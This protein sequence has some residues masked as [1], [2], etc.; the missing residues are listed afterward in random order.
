MLQA[1]WR[2]Q[3]WIP[4]ICPTG[5]IILSLLSTSKIFPLLWWRKKMI[6]T[7]KESEVFLKK[8]I[9]DKNPSKC[10]CDKMTALQVSVESGCNNSEKLF[11]TPAN[12]A[13]EW[14]RGLAG[15]IVKRLASITVK[16]GVAADYVYPA[17]S[18]PKQI[19]D[20]MMAHWWVTVQVI[21]GVAHQHP[22]LEGV[23]CHCWVF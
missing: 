21:D 12:T 14:W 6:E 15:E 3:K 7:R 20:T 8:D 9:Q 18:L 2:I 11:S 5:L 23:D 22:G 13:M 17:V 4:D 19:S 16:C 10:S 1:K